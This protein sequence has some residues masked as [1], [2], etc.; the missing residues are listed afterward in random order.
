VR[1][2][3]VWY[4]KAAE[5][6]KPTPL[7]SLPAWKYPLVA[8][9]SPIGLVGVVLLDVAA[10]ADRVGVHLRWGSSVYSLQSYADFR[11]QLELTL[12]TI[13]QAVFQSTLYVLGSSRATRIYIDQTAFLLSITVSLLSILVQ[14]NLFLHEIVSSKASVVDSLKGRFR[15]DN[16]QPCLLK[17]EEEPLASFNSVKEDFA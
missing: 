12:R 5:P 13:P 6:C 16:C 9:L 8:L 10:L 3:W 4:T 2:K 7:E 17:A 14:Y 15:V 1:F 11:A